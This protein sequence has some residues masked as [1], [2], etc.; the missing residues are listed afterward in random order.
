MIVISNTL[1]IGSIA[2]ALNA[3]AEPTEDAGEALKKAFLRFAED[4]AWWAEAAKVQR[5]R[6]PPP[7]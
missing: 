7:Y 5:S 3:E 4:L 6:R 2:Q 1:A